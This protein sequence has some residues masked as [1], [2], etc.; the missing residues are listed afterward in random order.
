VLKPLAMTR[1][2]VSYL[3]RKRITPDDVPEAGSFISLRDNSN[4]STGGEGIDRTK[5]CIPELKSEVE[6]AAAAIPGLALGGFD[7]IAH[8]IT[9][10]SSVQGYVLIEANYSPMIQMHHYPAKGDAIDVSSKIIEHAFFERTSI[11]G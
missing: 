9:S 5:D 7:L 6:R 2:I 3:A 11:K 8:D 1:E 4:I 10:L